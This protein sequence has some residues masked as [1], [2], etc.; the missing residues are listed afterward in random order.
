MFLHSVN[1]V[2]QQYELNF[3]GYHYPGHQQG[4]N[5]LICTDNAQLPQAVAEVLIL[6]FRDFL[7]EETEQFIL[8]V[9]SRR[10]QNYNPGHGN[11]A[12][13][14]QPPPPLRVAPLLVDLTDDP[15]PEIVD[16]T[17]ADPNNVDHQR[18]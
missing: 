7:G 1:N 3:A 5:C 16:L 2:A 13:D 14:E 8:H 18:F 6:I 12:I 4:C 17:G 11:A 10:L 9:L 15:I